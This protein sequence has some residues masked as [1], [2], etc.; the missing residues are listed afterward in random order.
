MISSARPTPTPI[1]AGRLRPARTVRGGAAI[2][3]AGSATG[4]LPA[5]APV[6]ARRRS[7]SSRRWRS[8]G[9]RCWP[10][11][12]S[13]WAA[14]GSARPPGR[15]AAPVRPGSAGRGPRWPAP[16]RASA[17]AP[18]RCPGA[19]S[20]AAFGGGL[21]TGRGRRRRR[22]AGRGAGRGSPSRP[23][24]KYLPD[25][26]RLPAARPGLGRRPVEACRAAR[27]GRAAAPGEAARDRAI[28]SAAD[29]PVPPPCRPAGAGGAGSPVGG[30]SRSAIR[31]R[32]ARLLCA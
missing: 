31:P 19:G 9:G 4:T 14:G 27:D 26:R 13:G 25:A 15:L 8:A 7:R 18:R 11:P 32:A 1:A 3:M 10:G 6:A 24:A 30:S 23:D 2:S 29:S 12:A 20:G 21:A 17:A 5:W 16:G 28:S 22:G